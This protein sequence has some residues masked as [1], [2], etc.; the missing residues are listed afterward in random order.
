MDIHPEDSSGGLTPANLPFKDTTEVTSNVLVKDG[1]TLV[2]GGLFRDNV[3]ARTQQIPWVGNIPV[4]GTLF[5]GKLDRAVREEMIVLITPHIVSGDEATAESEQ[6]RAEVERWRVLAHR[7]LMP[8]GRERLAQAHYRW[9]LEHERAGRTDKAL[10]DLE[11][12]LWLN[13]RF[14]EADRLRAQLACTPTA[15]PEYSIVHGVLR[16][17]IEQEQTPPTP[18]VQHESP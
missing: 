15:E 7:G 4:L 10:W 9:A 13:P 17:L 5:R 16:R 6:D 14:S 2:I 3:N 18:E 1:H 11:L 12:A 8:W